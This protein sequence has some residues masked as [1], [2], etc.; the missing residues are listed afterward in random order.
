L[1]DNVDEQ[2]ETA[3]LTIHKGS[4]FRLANP[5]AATVSIIND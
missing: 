1:K 4:G 2:T 5:K 3:T